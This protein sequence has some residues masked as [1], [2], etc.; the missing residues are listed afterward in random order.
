MPIRAERLEE[1]AEK[2]LPRSARVLRCIVCDRTID[3]D[4]APG[5]EELM[6]KCPHCR[7]L[8]HRRFGGNSRRQARSK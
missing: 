7:T 8:Q 2:P 1:V 6:I 4:A 5:T 3:T